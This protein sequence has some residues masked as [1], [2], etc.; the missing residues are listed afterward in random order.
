[1]MQWTDVTQVPPNT[2]PVVVH[3][4]H[5]Y[6]DLSPA[7]KGVQ[8]FPLAV[9]CGVGDLVFVKALKQHPERIV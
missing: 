3:D 1:M 4:D 7:F 2:H 9:G 5:I 8:N 6:L